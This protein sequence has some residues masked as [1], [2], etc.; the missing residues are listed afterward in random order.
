MRVNRAVS[1]TYLKGIDS[2]HSPKQIDLGLAPLGF[3]ELHPMYGIYKLERD[4]LTYCWAGPFKDRPNEFSAAEGSKHTLVHLERFSTGEQDVEKFLTDSGVGF[5]KEEEVGWIES[6]ELTPD[7]EPSELFP[8]IANLTRLR[9]LTASNVDDGVMIWLSNHEHL[10]HLNLQGDS[11]TGSGIEMLAE[12][13]SLRSLHINSTSISDAALSS[14][15]RLPLTSLILNNTRISIDKLPQLGQLQLHLLQLFDRELT[16][17]DFATIVQTFPNLEQLKLDGCSFSQSALDSLDGLEKLQVL[18]LPQTTVNDEGMQSIARLQTLT[19][20]YL[21]GTDITDESLALAANSLLNLQYFSVK[22][23]SK[24]TDNGLEYLL[25]ASKL[26]Y[27]WASPG[28][29]SADAR[30]RF[31]DAPQKSRVYER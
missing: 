9:R 18:S 2:S 23:N 1:T 3:A 24:I 11:L 4:R 21:D 22:E 17:Q 25:P 19:N 20:L 16:D 15:A 7:H 30:K 5:T 6:I 27:F 26:I 8:T 10:A 14:I 28:T 12:L 29:F 31:N 13:P